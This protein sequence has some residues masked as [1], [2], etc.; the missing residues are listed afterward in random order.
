MYRKT[1]LENG[2]QIVTECMPQ[3]RSVAMSILINA[4]PQDEPATQMGL[5]HL[6]EHLM[7]QGTGSRD[8]MQ[9]AR[10]IDTVGG[11]IGAFTSRDYT[12]YYA[13]VLDDYRTYALDLLGDILL[14]SIYPTDSLEREKEAILREIA[15]AY[16][17]PEERAH[18]L[19]KNLVWPNHPLGRPIAG[20]PETVKAMTREDLIYFVHEHYV[21]NRIT[22]A[23]AG[24][25]EHDDFVAQVRDCFWRMLGESQPTTNPPPTAQKGVIIENR[26]VS[27]TYFA[28]GVPAYAYAHPH[29]YS[30]HVLNN[31]LGGGISSRLFRRIREERGLVYN[32]GS[33]Y[34]AYRDSGLWV[35]E[36]STAPEYLMSVLALT[37]IQVWQLVMGDEPVDEEELWKTKMQ[38]RGQ[39]LI[40]SEDTYTRM[41]RL[42]TQELYFGRH[43]TPD[44]IL[45]EIDAVDEAALRHTYE[46]LLFNA[47]QSVAI[48]IVGPQAPEHYNADSVEELLASFQQ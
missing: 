35:I 23:A 43:I 2:I 1:T 41:S 48:S 14:N 37:L 10:M 21:P 5:A 18:T 39:H 8:A 15:A 7:F 45:A 26:D 31:I 30:L 19:L 32:I 22:I 42:A 12:C 24:N 44:E 9:I 47:L 29:R 20:E 28:I 27:Q 36:G 34:H 11:H 17:S 4:G 33:E 38:I 46:N 16:D 25:I 40:A 6:T 3:M 13:S